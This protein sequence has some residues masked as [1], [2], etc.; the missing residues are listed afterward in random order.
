MNTPETT[1][2][3]RARSIAAR[4]SLCALEELVQKGSIVGNKELESIVGGMLDID[5]WEQ[6]PMPPDGVARWKRVL[7]R[8]LDD[9]EAAGMVSSCEDGWRICN[10]GK[11]AFAEFSCDPAG[12]ILHISRML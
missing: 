4:C 7:A 6:C 3:G 9:M 11:A 2:S 12:L 8:C 10:A 5:D 1:R